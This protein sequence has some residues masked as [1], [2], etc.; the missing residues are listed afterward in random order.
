MDESGAGGELRPALIK[1]DLDAV[2]TFGLFESSGEVVGR[3]LGNLGSEVGEM[4]EVVV[5]PSV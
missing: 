4:D 2:V 1:E 3:E 5:F